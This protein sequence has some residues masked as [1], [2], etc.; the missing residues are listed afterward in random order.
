MRRRTRHFLL[1]EVLLAGL[2]A[3]GTVG[4]MLN[5]LV[6]AGTRHE[7]GV[8]QHHAAQVWQAAA[9]EASATPASASVDAVDP[10]YVIELRPLGAPDADGCVEHELRAV[11]R[12]TATRTPWTT[13]WRCP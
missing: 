10:G 12:A 6:L 9:L 4:L 8:Q 3:A 5:N 13:V 2:L 11:H 1:L 7:E